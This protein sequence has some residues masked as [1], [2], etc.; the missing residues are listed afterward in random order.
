MFSGQILGRGPRYCPSIEDKVFRF[1]DKD[2]HQIFLEPE[3]RFSQEIYA[4]GLS[5]SLPLDVQVGFLRT[6]KGLENVEV[7]RAGYA[8]EYDAIQPT[9]LRHTMEVKGVAGLFF[10]GQ[11]NGTSGYEEAAAQGLM[12]G[13]NAVLGFRSEEPLVLGRNQAYI[14]VMI[15]DLVTRGCDEPYRMFTSRAEY[16][17]TLREDTADTRLAAIGH[18]IGLLSEASFQV[19][20][21][22]HNDINMLLDKCRSVLF[23]KSK[24]LGLLSSLSFKTIPDRVSLEE[25]LR[26]PE[27]TFAYLES[28]ACSQVL[29][30]IVF[31]SNDLLHPS[32]YKEAET[33]IKY[34]GYIQRE[35]ELIE[36]M[37]KQ[38]TRPVPVDT[39][40]ASILGLS[41][42]AREKLIKVK[43]TTLGQASRIPGLTP[44]A[45][46]LVYL[47]INRSTTRP[48][49]ELH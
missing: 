45:I 43:P 4:N 48:V 25:L 36:R 2:R 28:Q 3:S 15:D 41:N 38:E 24:D 44:A 6:I 7:A 8:V 29:E 32:I 16:R 34:A 1:A 47:H 40:Y 20:T 9:I 23:L 35:G 18:R 30:D 10:A 19:F 26:M 46:A 39:D 12:A 31:S 33:I 37:S 27:F 17:L 22:K 14:G 21:K 13:I 5:T 42:E 49:N 11:V